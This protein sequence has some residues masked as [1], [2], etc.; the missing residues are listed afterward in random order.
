MERE[1]SNKQINC[2]LFESILMIAILGRI[3]FH[4]AP[5]HFPKIYI[6]IFNVLILTLSFFLFENVDSYRN[7][8]GIKIVEDIAAVLLYAFAY[9]VVASRSIGV[10]LRNLKCEIN[11]TFRKI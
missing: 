3:E 1:T 4:H 6:K 5:E 2:V 10:A 11:F 7:I 8:L 9:Y